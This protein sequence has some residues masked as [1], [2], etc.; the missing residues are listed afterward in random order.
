MKD[1]EHACMLWSLSERG[2]GTMASL[3]N[4][5]GVRLCWEL[6][7]PKGPEEGADRALHPHARAQNV[8]LKVEDEH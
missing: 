2:G 7:E 3:R 5:F 8:V 6:E 4:N 1:S